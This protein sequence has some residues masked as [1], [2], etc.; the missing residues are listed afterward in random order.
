MELEITENPRAYIHVHH[1]R[2]QAEKILLVKHRKYAKYRYQLLRIVK[3]MIYNFE[4]SVI[5]NS[6][7]LDNDIS[8]IKKLTLF[9]VN[10]K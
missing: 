2:Y 4:F 5:S 9:F 3:Y 1:V 8:Y 6:I 10:T 7:S